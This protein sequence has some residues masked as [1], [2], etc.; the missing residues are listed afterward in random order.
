MAPIVV[1]VGDDPGGVFQE[2]PPSPLDVA[3]ML[4]NLRRQGVERLAC[5]AV[6]GW[7]EGEP[8]GFAALER[9]M[10]A[11][12]S[13]TMAVPLV[14]GAAPE[15][16]PAAFRRAS[17]AAGSVPADLSGLP[18]V[19]RRAVRGSLLAGHAMAGFQDLDGGGGDSFP[20]LAK[21]ED[22]VVFAF[23][24][25]VVM[26]R[27]GVPAESLEIRPGSHLRF[28]RGGP[29]VPI[30]RHGCLAVE[31]VPLPEL[32]QVAAESLIDAAPGL[33]AAGTESPVL[34]VDARSGAESATRDFTAALPLGVAALLSLQ[35]EGKDYPR[36]A[37]AQE[38]AMVGACVFLILAAAGMRRWPRR[39]LLIA[40]V[41]GLVAVQADRFLRFGIWLSGP[42]CLAG[43]L[44]A[45]LLLWPAPS[46]K[47]VAAA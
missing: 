39:L 19:N 5:A 6:L 18:V 1:E 32:P 16:M 4:S 25:V 10:A 38:L 12:R 28:G 35:G 29:V 41:L 8:L 36:A 27:L 14:R 9:E 15:P 13:L 26:Q 42:A 24:V 30:D 7:D 21:W 40:A 46:A 45:L 3:V 22:R 34:L 11:F 44:L 17:I 33:L 37:A 23:P 2:N 43:L 31:L 47:E 20:L